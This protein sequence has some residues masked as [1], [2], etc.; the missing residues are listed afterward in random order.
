MH[1]SGAAVAEV[2]AAIKEFSDLGGL[3]VGAGLQGS[4]TLWSECA[5][6]LSGVQK[7]V[8]AVLSWT[9]IIV[10]SFCTLRQIQTGDNF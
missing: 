9:L 8:K 3:Q 7:L 2:G 6:Q 4:C 10:L 5:T 1:H